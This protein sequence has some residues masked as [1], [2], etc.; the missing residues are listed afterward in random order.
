MSRQIA[1]EVTFAAPCLRPVFI[2]G[3]RA[4]KGSKGAGIRFE[5]SLAKALKH[6]I[7][8]QWFHFID[9]N[10]PG[11][12]QPDLIICGKKR[13]IVLEC[14]L[15]FT[16]DA[17][18]QLEGLY[19]PILTK[20]YGTEVVGVVVCKNLTPYMPGEVIVD[21]LEEAISASFEGAKAPVLQWLGRGP[22]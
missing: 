18:D 8:G 11:W 16:R 12:C 22:V 14:K 13:T 2:P 19:R 20:A 15:T 10:G 5:R 17:H 1:G 21:S 9:A 4:G 6:A 3:Q 7:H